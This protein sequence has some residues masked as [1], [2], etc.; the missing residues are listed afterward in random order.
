M[1]YTRTPD[2]RLTPVVPEPF[3]W[4]LLPW[5]WRRLTGWRDAYG[6]SARF[7]GLG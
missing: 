2:G 4:G 5:L 6:R 3:L 7:I 1:N